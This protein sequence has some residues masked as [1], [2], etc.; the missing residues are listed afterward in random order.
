MKTLDDM[1]A[2]V[3]WDQ[4]EGAD[5]PAA[6]VPAMVR[7]LCSPDPSARNEVRDILAD[8]L[9]YAPE[10]LAAM[11]AQEAIWLSACTKSF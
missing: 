6:D 1:L 7:Q 10:K 11:I 4:L 3:P 5:G 9:M 2:G 8:N